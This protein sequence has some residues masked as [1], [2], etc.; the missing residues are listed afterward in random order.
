MIRGAVFVPAVAL[1]NAFTLQKN[2]EKSWEYAKHVFTCFV[3]LEIRL[4]SL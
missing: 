3:G 1:Q 4:G 2:F